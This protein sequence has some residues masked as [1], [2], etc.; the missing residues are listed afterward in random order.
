MELIS[1]LIA[2]IELKENDKK[3]SLSMN[4]KDN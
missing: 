4:D 2:F 3:N 1:I